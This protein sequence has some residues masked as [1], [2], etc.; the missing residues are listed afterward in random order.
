M[1]LFMKVSVDQLSY[2]PLGSGK[3]A[4]KTLA[5]NILSSPASR[6]MKERHRTV[7]DILDRALM[8]AKYEAG[9]MTAK[10]VCFDLA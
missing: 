9:E 2:L 10:S 5:D 4:S 7:G 8:I 6:F 1:G 3:G